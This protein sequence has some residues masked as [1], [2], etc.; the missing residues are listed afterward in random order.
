MNHKTNPPSRKINF[1]QFY[2]YFK[3][4]NSGETLQNNEID[5]DLD[6]HD[7]NHSITSNNL[8]E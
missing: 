6:N 4:V 1:N 5:L 2:E 3:K 7:F 8:V